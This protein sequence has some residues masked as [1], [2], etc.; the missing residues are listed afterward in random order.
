MTPTRRTI[1]RWG[2]GSLAALPMGRGLLSGPPP[3]GITPT[4]LAKWGERNSEGFWNAVRS[5]FALDPGIVYLN[6]G[7]LGPVPVSVL[8]DLTR[9]AADIASNPTEKMWGPL[10][11]RL[12]EVRAKAAKLLDVSPDDVALTR[13]TTEGI[14]T[15]GMGLGLAAGDEVITTDQE[16]P[17]G[18][19]VWQFLETRGVK[20]VVV[21]V[22]LPPAPEEAFL[23]RVE[24]AITPRTRVLALPHLTFGTGH[25]LPLERVAAIPKARAVP[26]CVDG[27]HPPG[28]LLVS[29]QKIPCA[30][31]ASSSHKWLLSPPGTGTLYV[32]PE[33]RERIAPRVFTGTGFTGKT[34]R[35]YDDFGTRNLAEVLAQGSALDFQFLVGPARIEARIQELTKRLRDGLAK[36]PGVHILTPLEPGRSGG[37]T[38]FRIEDQAHDRILEK[39][40]SRAHFVL[41]AVPELDAIRVSPGIYTTPAEIDLLLSALGDVT[42][43]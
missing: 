37:L 8:Q 35:R 24:A 16:H 2:L 14:S 38:A 23:D 10:G 31:Y 41:R 33:A 12:E 13:N 5:C 22:P 4:D 25:L 7:S 1:L 11:N 40:K 19:G 15:V 20:R 39:L 32:S 43:P 42:S 6:N 34:A 18:S 27:A 21:P 36:L 26:L 30:S 3:P 29:P 17:G 28:M 9:F